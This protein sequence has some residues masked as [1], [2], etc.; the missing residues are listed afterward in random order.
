RRRFRQ[1]LA[2]VHPA[3]RDAEDGLEVRDHGRLD[4]LE[5]DWMSEDPLHRG[6]DAALVAARPDLQELPEVRRD[7]VGEAV[8]GHAPMDGQ[9]D[10]RDL[11]AADPDAAL[12]SVARRLDAEI[13]AGSEEDL[14]E[15]RHEALH[16]EAVREL[17]DRI[18]D[19]LAG[20]VVR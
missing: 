19:E 20:T 12:G 3:Q 10:R 9:T 16:L 5:I 1:Q 13:R 4:V 18:A 11:L 7:V 17:E 6:H 8:E 2:D 14:L 15:V